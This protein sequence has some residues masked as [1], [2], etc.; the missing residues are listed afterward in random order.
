MSPGRVIA[1]IGIGLVGLVVL[2]V[3]G[4]LVVLSSPAVARRVV[5]SALG[6]SAAK[7]F[8]V[9]TVRGPLRG[10]L[11]LKDIAYHS[12]ALTVMVDSLLIR[13]KP[14]HLL[15]GRVDLSRL[16]V[17]GVRVV[18]PDS[19]AVDTTTPASLGKP[20]P[21]LP[22]PVILGDVSVRRIDYAGPNRVT[23]HADSMRLTGQAEAYGFALRGTAHSPRTGAVPVTVSGT[24]DLVHLRLEET[25]ATVFHGEVGATGRIAWWPLPAWDLSVRADS[26]RLQDLHPALEEWPGRITLLATS[27]G[28]VDSAGPSG[29][30]A[31]DTVEGTSRG[32]PLRGHAVGSFGPEGV[33]LSNLDARLGST[34][35]AASGRIG[36]TLA[37]SGHLVAANLAQLTRTVRGWLEAEGTASGPLA[38]PHIAATFRGRRIGSGTNRIEDVHG[39]TNLDLGPDGVTE[40]DI[41]GRTVTLA[42]TT[43]PALAI[44]LHGT[45]S[46]H[47][48]TALLSGPKDTIRLAARGR[49]NRRTWRGSL[50]ELAIRTDPVGGWHLERP[51]AIVASAS[52]GSVGD[53]CLAGDTVGERACGRGTWTS[54]RTWQ[55]QGTL[56]GL[57]VTALAG[58]TRP[59]PRGGRLAGSLSATLDARARN[60]RIDGTVSARADTV[61]FLYP[62]EGEQERRLALDSAVINLRSD[63]SGTT[64]TLGVRVLTDDK[65]ER[66]TMTGDATL[67]P[68]RIGQDLA[69]QPFIINLNGSI[70]DLRFLQP[71]VFGID[72]LAGSVVLNAN[73]TGIVSQP[74][75]HGELALDRLGIGL[76]GRRSIDGSANLTIQG[77]LG[78]DRS[79]HGEA[80]L[81]TRGAGYNYWYYETTRRLRVDT[82]AVAILV[83]TQGLHGDLEIRAADQLGT[84]LGYVVGKLEMP[85]LRQLGTP[86]GPEPVTARLQARIPDLQVLQPFALRVDSLAGRFDLDVAA[87]GRVGA[88]D[89]TGT[90][91]L[92][93][94][95]GRLPSGTL[96][97]GGLKGDLSL[98]VAENDALSGTVTMVPEDVRFLL[99]TDQ[100]DRPIRMSGT[101]IDARA[102]PSGVHG[103]LNLALADSAVG[104]LASFEGRVALP[105]LTRAG[106]PLALEPIEARLDGRA[107]DLAFLRILTRQID[108]AAGRAEVHM[109]MNGTL[110]DSRVVGNFSVTDAAVRLPLL[111][112]TYDQI[113]FTG[114]GD[115]SGTIAVR[116][117]VHSGGGEVT[118]AGTTPVI[119]T[120]AHP[121]HLELRGSRFEVADNEQ[122]HALIS[123]RL[124]IR[125]AGDSVDV[126]GDV[127]FPLARLVVEEVPKTVIRPSQDV[128]VVDS[129]PLTRKARP[130]S[131]RIRLILGDSVSFSAL[132]FD[133]E[134]AGTLELTQIANHIPTATGTLRIEEGR[135][136]SFGQDLTIKNGEIRYAGGPLNNPGLSIAATRQA[137]A[138]GDSIEVGIRIRGTAQAPEVELFSSQ[139]MSET[140]RLSYLL[141]GGPAGASSG[142]NLLNRALSSIGLKGGTALA[143]TLGQQV[144][145]SQATLSTASDVTG[146]ALQ[147]GRYLGPRL[148]VSYAI[149]VFDPVST[150]RLRYVLSNR[151]TLLAETGRTSG[152]D[153]LIRT[154]SEPP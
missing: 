79:M 105:R 68:Y 110:D 4:V 72:S 45:Q 139:A 130:L 97:E 87:K 81:A 86:L 90:L 107:A 116:G 75:I 121:G 128:V 43:Y 17:E 30:F 76:A 104:D 29:R 54:A 23:F 36:D 37:V 42:G 55:V 153:V 69:R 11:V 102:G 67:P 73:A 27:T 92:Q 70:P 65:V 12:G 60:G 52:H 44:E 71:L 56:Q 98:S 61:L 15:L 132:H 144:G 103:T 77:G 135:Y 91:Q 118:I 3:I 127:E 33:V 62:G 6:M 117:S 1:R 5:R 123:P 20:R 46:V 19:M 138:D 64:A 100:G 9:G 108:S 106:T 152:A 149:G 14:S 22:L 24:G 8:E 146:T 134:V 66:L 59:L 25:N 151:I 35:I 101:L 63:S 140:Q 136:Q 93:E 150:F 74:T 32:E 40:A 94:F 57:P 126:R 7:G 41:R 120:A 78:E 21:S 145:L 39:T 96:A 10:P 115:R 83:N 13:W 113:Q 112:V 95:R 111:G 16:L 143:Q 84:E 38:A 99:P 125:L 122:L 129:V 82:G 133:A 2:G 154:Q 31:I 89:L 88:P 109:A 142:G 18:F 131:G 124:D 119:P 85:R 58:A 34:T 48:L 137:M 141:T 26:L 47:R 28:V 80:I 51:V 147:L 50:T 53:L 148:Y 49:L 114:T